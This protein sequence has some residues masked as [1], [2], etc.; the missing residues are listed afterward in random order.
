MSER[1]LCRAC[2]MFDFLSM[3]FF[4]HWKCL[5]SSPDRETSRFETYKEIHW[6]PYYIWAHSHRNQSQP[7]ENEKKRETM[8]NDTLAYI[9]NFVYR[10]AFDLSSICLICFSNRIRSLFN[11]AKNVF[12]S[13]TC[14]PTSILSGH[15]ENP[16]KWIGQIKLIFRLASNAPFEMSFNCILSVD[17]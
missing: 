8:K 12:I 16:I 7:M 15:I 6:I 11:Q 1:L 13:F 14:S 9:R 10:N 17:L 2:A 3:F 5:N 4:V